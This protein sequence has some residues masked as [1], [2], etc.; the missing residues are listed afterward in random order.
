MGTISSTPITEWRMEP[1]DADRILAFYD[2]MGFVRI[3]QRLLDRLKQQNVFN[4]K[5]HQRIISRQERRRRRIIKRRNQLE[6]RILPTT[7][8]YH[9]DLFGV[10]F[11]FQCDRSISFLTITTIDKWSHSGISVLSDVVSLQIIVRRRVLK[12]TVLETKALISQSAK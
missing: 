3:K 6:Y 4:F 5:A 7:K 12:L 8:M 1:M 2:E 10:D 11:L 9:F